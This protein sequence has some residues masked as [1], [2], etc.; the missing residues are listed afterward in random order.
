MGVWH[1][2]VVEVEADVRRLVHRHGHALAQREL[3]AGKRQQLGALGFEGLAH[4]QGAVLDPPPIGGR[5]QAPSPSLR[6]EVVQ[7]GELAPGEKA[8]ADV[9]DVAFHPTLLV[10][11]RRGHRARLEAVVAGQGQ[12]R[13]VE[14]DGVTDPRLPARVTSPGGSFSSGAT[15]SRRSRSTGALAAGKFFTPAAARAS[16]STTATAVHRADGVA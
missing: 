5:A 10:A 6:V 14:A 7:A 1:G 8:V 3:V 9:A 2:V 12:Q 13:R 16:R 4:A 15:G 11:A